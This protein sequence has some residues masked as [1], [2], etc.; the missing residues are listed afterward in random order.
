MALL[1]KR[2]LFC[3]E[4]LKDLNG[5]Q[6]AVRAGYAPST[7]NVNVSWWLADPEVQAFIAELAA[8]RNKKLGIEADDILEELRKIALADPACAYDEDG[9]FKRDIHQIPVHVRKNIASIKTSQ[10]G[11]IT[12][13][14]FHDKLRALEMLARHLSLFNDKVKV[15]GLDDVAERILQARKR[16]GAT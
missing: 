10:N 13:V 6:A 5:A 3:R 8:E 2:E 1:P 16:A 7:A 15:E 11:Q 9:A 4:Y 14:K 12:E